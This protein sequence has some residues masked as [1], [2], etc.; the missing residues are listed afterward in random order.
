MI[1]TNL[2]QFIDLYHLAGSVEKVKVVS[3]GTN[4]STKFVTDDRTLFGTITY[5]DL[6]MEAGE[7]GVHDTKQFKKMIGVLDENITAQINKFGNRP[8]GIT[9][10][11]TGTE[12]LVMLADLSVIPEPPK[13]INTG[14]IGLEITMDE[15]FIDRFIRAK[16]SLSDVKTFTL[17]TNEKTKRVELIIGHSEINSNRIKLE[18]VTVPGKDTLDNEVTFNAD[19]F[20]EIL[21]KHQGMSGVVMRVN[22][23]GLAHVQFKTAN[24]DAN[25]YLLKATK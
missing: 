19:I 1:K 6:V 22:S 11:D 24:Y 13:G 3:D 7:Y 25:Y 2:L 23:A 10:S 21:A 4:L 14:K 18:V 9:F 15:A 17:V 20:K 16:S 8:I 5:N 12:S